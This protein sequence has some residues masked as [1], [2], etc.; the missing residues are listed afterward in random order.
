M[1]AAGAAGQDIAPQNGRP[2]AELSRTT[3]TA[4]EAPEPPTR[5][6]LDRLPIPPCTGRCRCSAPV[7]PD[8][9]GTAQPGPTTRRSRHNV[10]DTRCSF[11]SDHT[12]TGCPLGTAD[13]RSPARGPASA[14]RRLRHRTSRGHPGPG[15][16]PRADRRGPERRRGPPTAHRRPRPPGSAG[17]DGQ[18][19]REWQDLP[20]RGRAGAGHPGYPGTLSSITRRV[21]GH[22][23]P[24]L[25][26]EL[27]PGRPCQSAW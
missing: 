4:H 22:P 10:P 27:E 6:Y 1:P 13:P 23:R 5:A 17:T 2:A 7:A 18:S 25:R 15:R 11:R 19:P 14:R 24:P 12:R 16:R 21:R 20:R 8:P 26:A 3:S 9:G